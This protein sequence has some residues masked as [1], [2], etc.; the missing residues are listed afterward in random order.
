M[1]NRSRPEA[2]DERRRA[3]SAEPTKQT[4]QTEMASNQDAQ[5][6]EP[7]DRD[8]QVPPKWAR[9][10]RRPPRRP[11]PGEAPPPAERPVAM[12]EIRSGDEE[13]LRR[14]LGHGQDG[15]LGVAH[16]CRRGYPQV[17]VKAPL[18][19]YPESGILSAYSTAY[20]LSCPLLR[21]SLRWLERRGWL[22]AFQEEVDGDP[23]LQQGLK[24][25]QREHAR[26]RAA[27]LPPAV[28]ERLQSDPQLKQQRIILE[29][30]GVAGV[31]D[32]HSVKCLHAHLAD[33]LARGPNP[34][35]EAVLE[36]L[37]A[38][39]IPPEGTEECEAICN[40]NGP[41]LPA[42]GHYVVGVPAS[43]RQIDARF[44]ERF[45]RPAPGSEPAD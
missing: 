6:D 25:A 39:G 43:A 9:R 31:T 21:R 8:L 3:L 41:P 37:R 45:G 5:I 18:Y 42:A 2:A 38:L 11:I 19:E 24:E 36:E 22:D 1:R 34:I 40:P 32:P 27:L 23:A 35:G 4:E 13:S 20:W 26:V 29:E 30:T 7:G 14:Q 10:R 12:D 33:H 28:R 44:A 16:R 15:L 17:T